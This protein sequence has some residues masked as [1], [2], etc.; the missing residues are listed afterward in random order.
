MLN[1]IVANTPELN[2]W[3]ELYNPTDAAITLGAGWY[4]SDDGGAYTNLM[5]WQIPPGTTIPAHGF[6]SFDE[7]AGFHNP[8]NTGFALSKGGD[9]V[10][11][12]FLPGNAQDR[13]VDAVSFKAQEETWSLGRHP[14]G[15]AFWYALS[16]QTRGT[17]NAPPPHRAVI[18]ELMYHPQD[19]LVGTNLTDNSLDEFIEIASSAGS[20]RVTMTN[21]FNA[22]SWQA[23]H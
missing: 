18:S 23:R 22:L 9:E 16:S 5:K 3:I 7:N 11:L 13:V 12:S 14:D 8:T 2:D 4:L 10:F 6:V 21:A 20:G 19:I 15:G 1:E 17:T